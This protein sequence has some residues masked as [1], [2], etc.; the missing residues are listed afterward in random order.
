MGTID[1]IIAFSEQIATEDNAKMKKINDWEKYIKPLFKEHTGYSFD[2]SYV[3]M[4]RK[5]WKEWLDVKREE[6]DRT[7][8]N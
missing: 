6:F 3:S 8:C 5:E 7:Y 2:L 1:R 4:Y